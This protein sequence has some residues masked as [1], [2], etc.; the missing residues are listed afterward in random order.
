MKI[1]VLFVCL[2]NICRSP[3]AE[4][5]FK[6]KI[7][8][9]GLANHFHIDSAGTSQYHI[10]EL[11]DPRSRKSAEENRLKILH[12]ARQILRDDLEKFDYVLAMDRKNFQDILKLSPAENHREKVFLIRQFCENGIVAAPEEADVPDPYFG[13]EAGFKNVFQL[14]DSCC[15][16]FLNYL[17]KRHPF[18][19]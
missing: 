12:R 5:I 3:L 2:G 16:N 8:E 14:L 15:A 13:G 19:L 17:K 11:A 4:A 9:A 10:G 18:V 1:N 7:E 6:S